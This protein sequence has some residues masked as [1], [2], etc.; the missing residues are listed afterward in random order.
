MA[1]KKKPAPSA[2]ASAASASSKAAALQAVI[3]KLQHDLDDVLRAAKEAHTAATH[4]EAKPEN[5]KDTRGL[6]ESYLAAGQAARA[7]E[8]QRDLQA[9]KSMALA[10]PEAAVVVAPGAIVTLRDDDTDA[11]T[12]YFVLPAGAGAQVDVDG[13]TALVVT[14]LAPLARAVMGKRALDVIDVVIAG[15]ARS[16]AIDHVG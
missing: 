3:A 13:H 5:D 8:L 1:T 9:L 11:V 14:P 15:K 10:L 2:S 7:G 16:F 12:R 6:V 4:E